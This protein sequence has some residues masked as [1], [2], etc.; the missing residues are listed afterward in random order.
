MGF[1]LINEIDYQSSNPEEKPGRLFDLADVQGQS[2]H[3]QFAHI[4]DWAFFE[5]LFNIVLRF[6]NP[7]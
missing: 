3:A 5:K 4:Q 1:A 2:K 7:R 6:T